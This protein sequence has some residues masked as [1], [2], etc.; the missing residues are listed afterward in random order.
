MSRATFM[1]WALSRCRAA[2]RRLMASFGRRKAPYSLLLYAWIDG[3]TGMDG[4]LSD[5]QWREFGS[6]LDRIHRSKL[7]PAL[8]RQVPCETFAPHWS[9]VVRQLQSMMNA[10]VALAG[11]LGDQGHRVVLAAR[12]K[13]ELE[14]VAVRRPKCRR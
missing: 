14:K 9:P 3:P 10:G 7:P 11:Q 13:D 5:R 2:A 8:V 1:T 12:R 6:V 4:G